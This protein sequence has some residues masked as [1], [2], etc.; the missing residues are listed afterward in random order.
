MS[1]KKCK[2]VFALADGNNFYV[3]C[4]R[5]FDPSLEGKPVVVLSNNDGII[6][7]RSQEAKDL[8]IAMGTPAFRIK[9]WIESGKV[10]AFSSNYALYGDMSNRMMRI[11]ADFTPAVEVYSID[12]AFLDF[13]GME[14]RDWKGLGKTIRQ[15][16]RRYI[17]IPVGIG[18]GPTKTL[19]KIA[20]RIA[21]KLMREVGV[22]VVDTPGKIRRALELT[23]VEDVWGIGRRYA[24]LLENQG[25]RTAADFVRL[26]DGWIRR[27]MTVQ[28]LRIKRELQGEPVIAL[29]EV[30]PPRM[31][32]RT[33]R[34][35]VEDTAD[36]DFI[37]EA[38][39]HFTVRASQKLRAQGSFARYITVFLKTNRFR[40]S[41]PY[42]S[43]HYTVRLP[44]ATDSA[45]V[46]VHY[47]RLALRR[48][49]DPAYV[50]KKAGI[51]L[52]DL[53]D[54]SV[55]QL[56]LFEPPEDDRHRRLM[57][58]VDRL[59]RRYG[60]DTLR[61]GVQGQSRAWQL[62]QMHRS[63]RYTT[64]WDEIPVIYAR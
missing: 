7:A 26:P 60:A 18:F 48:I 13:R 44:Y 59:N 25:V 1:L 23:P 41:Q 10:T 64:R 11:F 38:I 8:G 31:A 49:Y 43:L 19:A 62:K 17:G 42:R 2:P 50:Y 58:T 27:H 15:R 63:P 34:T 9:D 21:K 51:L 57:E 47:A 4:E 40:S 39:A 46:L 55:R 56:N 61:L 53:Q 36:L 20:N 22:A 32:I 29:E 5:V 6:I 35:F 30:V 45:I 12:E 24:R 16:V 28:G 14:V 33:A 3:S 37:D 52:S 54:R